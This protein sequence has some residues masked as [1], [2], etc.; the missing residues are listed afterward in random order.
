MSA[1]IEARPALIE[2]YKETV[3]RD[4]Y[5]L[6]LQDARKARLQAQNDNTYS[7]NIRNRYRKALRKFRTAKYE[8]LTRFEAES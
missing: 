4:Q 2:T 3:A 1:N 8:F 5:E 7:N 6:Y